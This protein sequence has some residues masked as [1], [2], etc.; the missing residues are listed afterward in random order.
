MFDL[1]KSR[2]IY[3]LL[4]NGKLI[5]KSIL[6]NSGAFVENYLFIEIINNLD[7]YRT[8][9]KMS[10]YELVEN[11]DFFYIRDA[12]K[13]DSDLKTD[14]TMKVCVLLLIMGKYLIEH[15]HRLTRL[16]EPSGGVSESDFDAM[17]EMPNTQE[18]LYKSKIKDFTSAVK[19]VLI[20]RNILL[21]KPSSDEY[22][23]SDGG[24]A[25]FQEIVSEYQV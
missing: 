2:E 9:Y 17:Q 7:D 19:S 13:Q 23:L 18:I 15:N 12:Q 16:T 10:G 21:Q 22:I 25:F 8:Q 1:K 14:I 11:A 24:R 3:G 6:N 20:D 5:N 4:M